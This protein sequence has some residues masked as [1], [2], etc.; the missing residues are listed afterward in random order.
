MSSEIRGLRLILKPLIKPAEGKVAIGCDDGQKIALHQ[1]GPEGDALVGLVQG[2]ALT[3]LVQGKEDIRVEL[4]VS[5]GTAPTFSCRF[6]CSPDSDKVILDNCSTEALEIADVHGGRPPTRIKPRQQT[7]FGYGLW[8]LDSQSLP[9]LEWTTL[10]RQALAIQRPVIDRDAT[11]GQSEVEQGVKRRRIAGPNEGMSSATGVDRRESRLIG[12]GPLRFND[13]DPG[14]DIRRKRPTGGTVNL[15]EGE[16]LYLPSTDSE[17]AHQ[18]T[19]EKKIASNNASES[20]RARHS[21]HGV[22]II[23]K[24]LRTPS[25]RDAA[26]TKP[27]FET[28]LRQYTLQSKTDHVRTLAVDR[29]KMLI[30]VE[31][32][33]EAQRLGCASSQPPYGMCPKP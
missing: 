17:D 1:P 32:G 2:D 29:I 14:P 9:I 28:W 25:S 8:R 11:T 27:Q 4:E 30:R 15:Q 16:T 21:S 23:V 3:G 10:P 18:L 31:S 20:F 33:G 6:H 13:T 5:R 26:S 7:D 19:V 24:V 12:T 22:C